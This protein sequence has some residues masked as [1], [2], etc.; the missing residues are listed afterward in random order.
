MSSPL[1]GEPVGALHTALLNA[2]V[3]VAV[4]FVDR[5]KVLLE[6]SIQFTVIQRE[7]DK[8]GNR[9]S[10]RERYKVSTRGYM[11]KIM[12]EDESE[13]ISYHW[14]PEAKGEVKY[15]HEHLGSALL[16]DE[17]L[18]KKKTHLRTGRMAFEDVLL[19]L[20]EMGAVPLNLSWQTILE[21]NRAAFEK[22][23]SWG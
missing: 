8:F 18:L 11:Y 7:E 2:G 17:G 5:T 23:K 10:A 20:L 14:H 13:I 12:Y 9:V 6:A 15:P 19:N 4:K 21:K 1:K 22:W 16:K 3:P